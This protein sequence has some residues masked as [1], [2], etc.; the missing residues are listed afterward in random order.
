MSSKQVP[1]DDFKSL[2]FSVFENIS[3]MVG[4]FGPLPFF[5]ALGNK[6]QTKTWLL[7]VEEAPN[8]Y[9]LIVFPMCQQYC[10]QREICTGRLL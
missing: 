9:D 1:Q 8:K 5:T 10:S 3:H 7:Y 6:K 4:C 2:S